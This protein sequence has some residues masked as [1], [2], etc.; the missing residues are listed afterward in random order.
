M[1]S[2]PF[3]LVVLGSGFSGSLLAWIVA[4]TGRRVLL[5][6]PVPHP[7]FAIGESSTP[8]ADFLLE[9][10]ADE[11][12]LPELAE[13]SRWGRWQE[14]HPELRAG[15]KRGFSYFQHHEGKGF[16]ESASHE[17]SLLVSAS[18]SDELSDTHWLRSDVD[19][20]FYKHALAAGAVAC[21][22]G[23]V[24]EISGRDPW[25]I[26]V[27]NLDES[28]ETETIELVA[29]QIVDASGAAAVI[30]QSLG[31]ARLDAQLQTRS[32]AIFGHF[33]GVGSMDAWLRSNGASTASDPF[34]SDDAAQHHVLDDGWIWMLRFAH[35]VTSVG[36]VWH[37][38]P[39]QL[40]NQPQQT[41][42][43]HWSTEIYRWPTVESLLSNAQL[44][45]P[46]SRKPPGYE[47]QPGLQISSRTSRLWSE[48]AG[49]DWM[50]LPST[51][52]IIDPLHSTGIAHSLWGVRQ[53]ARILLDHPSAISRPN[54]SE[55]TI[56]E[57]R[58]IDRLVSSAYES[59]RHG[60]DLF[61]GASCLYFI[62]AIECESQM[63]AGGQLHDGFLCW[64]NNEIQEI[65]KWFSDRVASESIAGQTLLDELRRRVEPWN[66]AGLLEPE[67]NN[68]IARSAADK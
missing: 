23:K 7:R 10:I 44:I 66:P 47:Q 19:H 8:L 18:T 6:D 5:V 13:L 22:P 65:V 28:G 45:A 26:S 60:F 31:L 39:E 27:H 43:D 48:A 15:K 52:G 3:D 1:K 16:S 32:G 64:R 63:A 68:R 29:K 42:Q 11:F 55:S 37:R 50:L 24:T 54:Y 33:E 59:Q 67:L 34:Y 35:G 53:V 56:S 51:A 41:L 30:P 58:L 9:Q 25:R 38:M 17:N 40:C 21:C 4:H 36:R 57:V 20:W 46:V 14:K 2:Q 12:K 61:C 49:E 62:C